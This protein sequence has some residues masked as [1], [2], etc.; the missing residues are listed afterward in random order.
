MSIFDEFYYYVFTYLKTKIKRKASFIALLYISLLQ[1]SLLFV[2]GVFFAAFFNQM[3]LNTLNEGEAWIL[4]IIASFATLTV[5]IDEKFLRIKFGYGIFRKRFLL[6]EINSAQAVKNHWYNG[7][8]VR[9]W[10]W[11]YMWIFNVSGFDAVEIKMN[12]GKIFRIGTD[13]PEKL[14]DAIMKSI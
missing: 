1:I 8:G 5:R 9:V 6:R 14:E 4:F 13:E 3:N 11:P 12:N 7:W 10:F 2:L